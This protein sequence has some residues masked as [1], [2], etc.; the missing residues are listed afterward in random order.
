MVMRFIPALLMF[1]AFATLVGCG[2]Q[3]GPVEPAQLTPEQIQEQKEAQ[4]KADAEER[5][6]MASQQSSPRAPT[7]EDE[8]RMHRGGR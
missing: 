4:Q 8:E 5:S 3:S 7:A 6:H 2:G 1:V